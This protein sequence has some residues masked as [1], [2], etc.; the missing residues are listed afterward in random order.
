MTVVGDVL[1]VAIVG[2][3]RDPSRPQLAHERQ[4]FLQIPR[5]RRLADQQPHAGA[6]PLAAFFDGQRLVVGVD[7]GRGVGLQ[8]APAHTRRVTVNV[9]RPREG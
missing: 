5:H 9:L 7:P 3:E 4:Q 6:Q 8:V 1:R 2:A